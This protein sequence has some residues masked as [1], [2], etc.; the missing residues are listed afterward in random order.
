MDKGGEKEGR[1]PRASKRQRVV[2]ERMKVVDDDTRQQVMSARLDALEN[3]NVQQEGGMDSDDEEYTVEL[4]TDENGLPVLPKKKGK[5]VK[6]KRKTRGMLEEKQRGP[7]TFA[8][9][10]EEAGLEYVPKHVP[11]Y[12]TVAAGPPVAYPGRKFCSVCGF[13]SRI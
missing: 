13:F 5:R 6:G 9:Q 4:T 3:D 8:G 12:L 7:T 11:T 1:A 10:L 2:S